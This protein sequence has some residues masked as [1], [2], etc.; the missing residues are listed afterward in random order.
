MSEE[1]QTLS[2]VERKEYEELKNRD[3]QNKSKSNERTMF[4]GF[5]VISLIATLLL[6]GAFELY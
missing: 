6:S 4:I 3:Q 5:F 1:L 2:Y